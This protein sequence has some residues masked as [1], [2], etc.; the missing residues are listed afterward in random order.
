MLR[1][2]I[3][4]CVFVLSFTAAQ[5]EQ[6]KSYFGISTVF[7]ATLDYNSSEYYNHESN[8]GF[9]FTYGQQINDTVATEFSYVR[10]LDLNFA[11]G[12][13]E[14]EL[15]AFEVSAVISSANSGGFVRLGY[16]NAELKVG[17]DTIN[18]D[19]DDDDGGLIY[20]LGYVFDTPNKGGAFRV[21]YTIGDYDEGDIKRLTLGTLIRF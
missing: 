5:A 10:Y 9:V 19:S 18:I 15:S 8:S 6:G 16:S 17:S 2:A 21:G 3:Y 1:Q 7:D 20:G 13:L 12:Y 4:F 14:L 11:E